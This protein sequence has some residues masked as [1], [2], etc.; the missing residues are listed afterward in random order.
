MKNLYY[1]FLTAIL[2][3]ANQAFA[4][5]RAHEKFKQL[6]EELPTPNQYHN[7]AGAPGHV[8]WQQ[9]ADYNI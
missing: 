3:L 9:K 4:Q 6:Y 7:A 2:V 1:L 5:E 8:Y